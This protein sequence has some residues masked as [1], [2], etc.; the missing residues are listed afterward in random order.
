MEF[1]HSY[2]GGWIKGVIGH[3]SGVWLEANFTGLCVLNSVLDLEGVQFE[4]VGLEGVQFE[5]V[6]SSISECWIRGSS[7]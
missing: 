4:G 6:G 7:I 3:T 5:G 1:S 2:P